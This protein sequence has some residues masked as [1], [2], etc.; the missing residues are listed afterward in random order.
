MDKIQ[1][2]LK[3]C[4][5]SKHFEELKEELQHKLNLQSEYERIITEME[6]R[7]REFKE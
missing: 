7:L 5:S 3:G 4:S 6:A 1:D 2:L